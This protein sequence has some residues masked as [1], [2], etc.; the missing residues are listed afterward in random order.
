MMMQMLSAGGL[1]ALTDDARPPDAA[2]QKGYFEYAPAKSLRR[3][4]AWV[5]QARGR[6]V[7]I[8]AQLLAALPPAR[9]YEYRV[10]FMERDLDEVVASQRDM[11]AAQGTT[12][13]NLSDPALQRVFARQ[14]RSI[15][16][17]LNAR[18][19]PVLYVSHRDCIGDPAAVAVRINAFLGGSLD[20]QAMSAVVEPD[21]Y[22]HRAGNK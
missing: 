5:P 9:D 14:L 22:R 15:T 11:I 4:S 13:A 17:L 3:D 1:E 20:E 21:L 10:V 16:R 18:R 2:N 6:V 12:G 8:V 19:A 7:K